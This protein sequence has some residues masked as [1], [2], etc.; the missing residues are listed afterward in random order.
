VV[1]PNVVGDEVA[2]GTR[3][4]GQDQHGNDSEEQE[5]AGTSTTL[6][7]HDGSH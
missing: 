7:A 3:S 4:R 6:R 2:A 1:G 5:P